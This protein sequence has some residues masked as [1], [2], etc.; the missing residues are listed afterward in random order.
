MSPASPLIV[1]FRNDLRLADNPALTAAVISGRPIIALYILQSTPVGRRLGAASKWW[2][3]GSLRALDQDMSAL[4]GRLTLRRGPASRVLAEIIRTE[5]ATA[6]YTNRVYEPEA[7]SRDE[8][9]ALQLAQSGIHVR[10]FNAALLNEP[11]EVLKDDG[12]AYKVFTP[13]WRAAAAQ[14]QDV[15]ILPRPDQLK[16]PETMPNSDCLDDWRLRPSRP[17]W[18][19]GFGDWKPGEA[20][21]H[22][23]LDAF[24][25]EGIANYDESRDHPGRAGTSSLSP[26]LRFGEIGPRQ[27]RATAAGG[28]LAHV[29]ASKGIEAFQRELGW[30]EFNY[31]I[32]FHNPEIVEKNF[33]PAF[34]RFR[35]RDD[36]EGLDA[37]REGRTGY[38]IVDAGMR[39]LWVTGWM[40]NRVRMIVAS[41][42]TKHL[43]IDW[44][45]GESWFWDTLVDADLANNVANWQ[46]VAGSGA[47]AAPYFRIFNPALQGARYDADGAYV[48]RWA[49]ELTGLPARVIHEPWRASE[50]ELR[51]AGV[52][53]GI[54]YPRPV[55]DHAQARTRALAAYRDI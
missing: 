13:Y 26:H 16:W 28:R 47:D 17:D 49:P 50:A 3:E 25:A 8:A 32:L 31:N 55:V 5:G 48:R 6:L 54:D 2:L 20:G 1:W 27:V 4:G 7:A 11:W 12:A 18:A 19:T 30:R 42:L 23:R 35:W 43:L 10:S 34:D 37:W 44:R 40:H 52:R 36:P 24:V 46:W 21:A 38:P 9:I 14:L 15:D 39:Q 53:L 45:L 22:A 51:S 29:G 41:F 33:Q